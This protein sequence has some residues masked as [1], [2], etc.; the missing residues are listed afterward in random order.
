MKRSNIVLYQKKIQI[1]KLANVAACVWQPADALSVDTIKDDVT[2]TLL[3]LDNHCNTHQN[4]HHHPTSSSKR[5]AW[6][7]SCCPGRRL[8]TWPTTADSCSTTL[9]ALCGQLTF[10]TC[11]LPRTLS[12]YGDRT[13]AAAGPRLWNSLPVQLCNHDITYGLFRR[14]LKGHLFPEAWTGHSVTSDMWSHRKTGTYL[15]TSPGTCHTTES[16][17]P[18]QLKVGPAAVTQNLL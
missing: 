1:S 17:D 2:Q 16:G 13:F 11:V 12:S 3:S 6:F 15:L 7:T 9:C 4:C 18:W 10:L 14:Q 5:H 8:S